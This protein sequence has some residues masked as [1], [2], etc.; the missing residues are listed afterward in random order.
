MK[1][2]RTLKSLKIDAE[3]HRRFKTSCSATEL[4]MIEVANEII[5]S[6]VEKEEAAARKNDKKKS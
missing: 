5:K 1:E 3:I 2:E 4:S 6:W